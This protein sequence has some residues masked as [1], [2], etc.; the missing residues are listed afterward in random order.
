MK[1]KL[2]TLAALLLAL[3]LSCTAAL[4]VTANATVTAP[5]T[6]KMAAPMNG[7]LLP[8]DLTGGDRVASGDV[9]FA[10]DT[11][12]VY[13]QA[14]GK[15]AAVFAEAG[16]DASGVMARYGSLAVIEP[17]KPLFIPANTA[18]AYDKDE[19]RYL[20]AGQTLY[21]KCGNEEGVGVVTSVDG[22][23][24][25]VEIL[26]GDFELGD[27][28]RCFRKED[29]KYEEETGR[30]KATRYADTAVAAQGRIVACHV[31]PGDAV[32]T[33]DL[34]FEVVDDSCAVGASLEMM[35]PVSG[36]VTALAVTSGMQV[37]RGQLLCE[38]A[39][40]DALELSVQ[41]DELDLASLRVGDVLTYTLDAYGEETFSGTVTEIRP[42][43]M[44][45]QNATYFDVRLTINTERMVLP[46][47]NGTVTLGK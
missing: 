47:M 31:Q 42:I 6:V 40:L 14:D 37:Y 2:I 26:E 33:G 38:I 3:I 22:A 32:K 24:Y 30:G 8:F 27:M 15:V 11:V 5:E 25:I 36:A 7:T 29:M 34:L 1:T 46:G 10:F 28:V 21:L 19:N 13:A 44:A 35:A 39:D 17:E 4:A 41:V 16:D 43:G 18:Q 9:L 45:R 20:H 12:P 23:N